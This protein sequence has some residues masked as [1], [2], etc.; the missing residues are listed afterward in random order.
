[1]AAPKG[2]ARYGGR[3]K[4]TPN[5]AHNDIQAL[6]DQV[7]EKV[8]PVEKLVSLLNRPLDTATEARVFLRLMEYRYGLP[9]QVIAIE[10]QPVEHGSIP[11]SY[12]EQA[13][14]RT[15]DKPN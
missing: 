12:F 4:G 9:R 3:Q 15:A 8:N 11:K 6:I 5:K 2:H 10:E 13:D 1:M 14:S 7:F